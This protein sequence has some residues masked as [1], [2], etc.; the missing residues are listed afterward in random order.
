MDGVIRSNIVHAPIESIAIAF[1]SKEEFIPLKGGQGTAYRSGNIIVKP[2]DGVEQ[3]RWLA[4]I[5]SKLP[6]SDNVR[7]ATPVRAI[8][9][10]WIYEGFVAWTFLEGEHI[11][12][13]YEKK[14]K[15]SFAFHDLI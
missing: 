3:S 10:E 12:G 4:E 2:A 15:G 8:T 13:D 1:G 5:F 6:E 11:K 7:L 9:G 14:I